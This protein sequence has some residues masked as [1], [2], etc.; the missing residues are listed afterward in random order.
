MKIL[1]QL[2]CRHVFV[3]SY[4]LV[5]TFPS[6][7]NLVLNDVICVLNIS[8][9]IELHNVSILLMIISI[10]HKFTSDSDV[11]TI[12]FYCFIFFLFLCLKFF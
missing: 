12:L 8:Y 9:L 6:N 2:K 1:H 3:K 10:H 11:K 7:L 4:C 5:L